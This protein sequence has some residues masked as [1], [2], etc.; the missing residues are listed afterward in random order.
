MNIIDLFAGC[1]GLTTGFEQAGFNS[2]LAVEMDNGAAETYKFN[3]PN[4]KVLIEDITKIDKISLKPLCID[5]ETISCKHIDKLI[6]PPK[7]SDLTT[8]VERS[9]HSCG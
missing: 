5:D 4:T 8:G 3:H 7:W 6:F 9:D 1:G 2:V